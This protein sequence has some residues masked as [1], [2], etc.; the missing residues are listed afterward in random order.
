VPLAPVVQGKDHAA[1]AAVR[2]LLDPAAEGG[3]LWGPRFLRSK[4]APALERPTAAMTGRETAGQLWALSE[5]AT[6]VR[7]PLPAA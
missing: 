1:W 5:E 6:A 2:A 4:G 3:Q 7:W